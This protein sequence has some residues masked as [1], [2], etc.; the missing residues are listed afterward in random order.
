ML[1]SN[2]SYYSGYWYRRTPTR[3]YGLTPHD[4][5]L[6]YDDWTYGNTHGEYMADLQLLTEGYV[7]DMESGMYYGVDE[8]DFFVDE[9][10]FLYWYDDIE[11]CCYEVAGDYEIFDKDGNSFKFNKDHA[12][13]MLISPEEILLSDLDEF[14]KEEDKSE[15]KE[16]I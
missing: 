3:A 6:L 8:N 7:I 14:P 10:G 1:F 16:P 2:A 4:Y 12:F 13:G 15:D 9:S 5:E 11:Q